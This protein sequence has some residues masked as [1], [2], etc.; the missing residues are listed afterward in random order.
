MKFLLCKSGG[1]VAID[2]EVFGT[3]KVTLSP[4]LTL[5]RRGG[6]EQVGYVPSTRES[7]GEK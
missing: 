7:G 1:T 5:T 4:G 3:K 2:I 6:V